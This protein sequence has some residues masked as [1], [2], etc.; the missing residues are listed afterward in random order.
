MTRN[1]EY[2][3]NVGQASHADLDVRFFVEAGCLIDAFAFEKDATYGF[4]RLSIGSFVDGVNVV[5][6]SAIQVSLQQIIATFVYRHF[7]AGLIHV[8][9]EVYVSSLHELNS[10]G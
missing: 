8:E 7:T 6:N 3:F 9:F 2:A 10:G 1:A 4:K 5:D